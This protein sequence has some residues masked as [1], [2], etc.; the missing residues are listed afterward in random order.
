MGW[1]GE[2]GMAE[3]WPSMAVGMGS[4]D[5]TKRSHIELHDELVSMTGDGLSDWVY[6]I[7]NIKTRELHSVEALILIPCP[8]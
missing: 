1:V 2:M 6:S 7:C 5:L 8:E 3:V 4:A